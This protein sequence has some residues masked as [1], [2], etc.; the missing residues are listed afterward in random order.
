M[1]FRSTGIADSV[2]IGPELEFFV[3]DDVR[4]DSQANQSYYHLDS[5]EG[6][7]NRG[8][9]EHPNLGYKLRHKEG[10]FPVPPADQLTDL[11]SEMMQILI[12]CGVTVEAHH[13][14]VAT[15]GQCEIDMKFAP[16]LRMADQVMIYKYI[17]K[18]AARRANKSATFMPKPIYGDNGDRK[19]TRLNSSH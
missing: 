10:Y 6:A 1:L 13:H 8:R 16:L 12:E 18:N 15:G 17:V 3:F 4:F 2:Q 19:S 11:R 14:E 9:D 7:W 5:S